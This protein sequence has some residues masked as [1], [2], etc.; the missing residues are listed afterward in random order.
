MG[1]I[2]GLLIPFTQ[3]YEM[4]SL[5]TPTTLVDVHDPSQQVHAFDICYTIAEKAG[6]R[7][8]PVDYPAGS[9][10]ACIILPIYER[11]DTQPL[12]MKRWAA[13]KSYIAMTT[14]Q[15]VYNLNLRQKHGVMWTCHRLMHL[16]FECQLGDEQDTSPGH[17]HAQLEGRHHESW[18]DD[19][20]RESITTGEAQPSYYRSIQ[21]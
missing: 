21:S 13:G 1:K 5:H 14:P 4:A 19:A 16:F 10:Q 2:I 12:R 18:L 8:V 17:F 11:D 15:D 7:W 20:G 3:M 9:K 6:A